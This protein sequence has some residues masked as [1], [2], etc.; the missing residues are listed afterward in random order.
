[1]AT[2]TV[3]A[4]EE[5]RLQRLS[6]AIIYN[7]AKT[8]FDRIVENM[9][10]LAC[11]REGLPASI[12]K[13]HATTLS[14][15]RYHIK[16]QYGCSPIYNSHLQPDPFLGSGQGA[17]DSMSRWGFVS[18][19]LIRAYN[20]R[21]I[22]HP[23]Q[24]P[25]SDIFTLDHIQAFVDDSHGIIIQQANNNVNNIDETIQHNIQQWEYLLNATVGKLE[26][27]KS[28]FARFHWTSDESG[29]YHLCPKISNNRIFIQ[30]HES[31]NDI[32]ISEISTSTAYKLL[33]IHITKCKKMAIAFA[34]CQLSSD[35]ALQGYR[36]IFLP[37]IRYGQT[38]TN[39]PQRDIQKSQQIVTPVLLAKLGF[40]RH[41]PRSIVY[42]PVASEV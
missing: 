6:G 25:I 16:T 21:A 34:R 9:S 36:S 22:S 15:M 30:D 5:C 17:G 3:L 26:I 39:I 33:G 2:K 14:T 24:A 20:K 42:A 12:A 41:T 11:M 31:G 7:D 8:C 10:N 23:I 32:A 29:T 40:N 19:A 1:M 4:H 37:A 18:D 35:E 28:N 38:A 27:S 13:L